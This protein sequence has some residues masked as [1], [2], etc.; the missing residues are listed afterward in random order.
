[1][2]MKYINKNPLEKLFAPKQ[3]E[4]RKSLIEESK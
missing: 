3:E 4:E 2:S 1:M